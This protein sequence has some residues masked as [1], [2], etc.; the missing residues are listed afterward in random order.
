MSI[1]MQRR[2]RGQPTADSLLRGDARL[3][4]RSR[5]DHGR[6]SLEQYAPAAVEG[7]RNAPPLR[8]GADGARP[9]IRVFVG[10]VVLLG[11]AAACSDGNQDS[12]REVCTTV[13]DRLVELEL[14]SSA[15]DRDRR[16]DV[17]RR[18]LGSEFVDHCVRSASHVETDCALAASDSRIAQECM[19]G[20]LATTT[21]AKGAQC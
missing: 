18:A 16:A 19:A 9:K 11:V 14:P 13:R 20:A 4:R 5:A 3:G 17:M 8:E 2:R 10:V 21:V 7:R 15:A 12:Q 1:E 6:V